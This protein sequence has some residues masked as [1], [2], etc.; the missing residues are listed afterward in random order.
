V[1]QERPADIET[2]SDSPQRSRE[3][4]AGIHSETMRGTGKREKDRV[5]E[6][7]LTMG[8]LKKS[9]L[10]VDD[11]GDLWGGRKPIGGNQNT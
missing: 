8:K 2:R 4:S 6:G 1:T 11:A 7:P 3:I 10:G 9:P 5:T